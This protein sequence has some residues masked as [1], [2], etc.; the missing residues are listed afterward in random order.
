MFFEFFEN[1][2]KRKFL[3]IT[4]NIILP[5]IIILLSILSTL[6]EKRVY[7]IVGA[8]ILFL[9]FINLLIFTI[10]FIHHN[11][12]VE[13]SYYNVVVPWKDSTRD[14][15]LTYIANNFKED[16]TVNY[17]GFKK[18]KLD[19]EAIFSLNVKRKKLLWLDFWYDTNEFYKYEKDFIVKNKNPHYIKEIFFNAKPKLIEFTL[20]LQSQYC[21]T[22]L[23]NLGYSLSFI[24]SVE[25]KKMRD[26]KFLSLPH[27]LGPFNFDIENCQLNF[28]FNSNLSVISHSISFKP[29]NLVHT[30]RLTRN[31]LIVN[32]GRLLKN[33]IVEV[34][35]ELKPN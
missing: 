31:T 32:I 29:I 7:T 22:I 26:R 6:I 23:K 25:Y 10:I 17:E 2:T 35:F 19:I 11:K 4:L 30:A 33:H 1:I 28:N 27:S 20:L 5:L 34:N 15:P 9:F 14:L 3:S 12:A 13:Q 21:N 24:E 16:I 18:I 8:C